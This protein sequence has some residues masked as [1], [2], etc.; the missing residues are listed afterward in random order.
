[1]NPAATDNRLLRLPAVGD[2][3]AMQS[4][5]PAANAPM[6]PS[7]PFSF[8][9]RLAAW[10]AAVRINLALRPIGSGAYTE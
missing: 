6:K 2:N 8:R 5:Q 3:A 10:R 4:E 1:M 9:P 7:L